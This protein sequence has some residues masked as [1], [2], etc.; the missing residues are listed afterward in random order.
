MGILSP[1]V[2]LLRET[3]QM[4]AVVGA[5]DNGDVEYDNAG[6]GD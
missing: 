2:A 5:L 4:M 1:L 3:G 6:P